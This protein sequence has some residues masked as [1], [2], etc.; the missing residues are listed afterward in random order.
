MRMKMAIHLTKRSIA[1]II[2]PAISI[3][4]LIMIDFLRKFGIMVFLFSN[5]TMLMAFS[6]QKVYDCRLFAFIFLWIFHC[7]IYLYDDVN[8]YSQ[9]MMCGYR[10]GWIERRR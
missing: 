7:V 2:I 8:I 10:E 9:R 5:Q 3:M 4:F 1:R 6:C